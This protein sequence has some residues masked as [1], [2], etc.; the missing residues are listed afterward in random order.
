M[1]PR[2]DGTVRATDSPDRAKK[3]LHRFDHLEDFADPDILIRKA[4]QYF[5]LLHADGLRE[6]RDLLYFKFPGEVEAK[7]LG[8]SLTRSE[9][10]ELDTKIAKYPGH[11]VQ[12]LRLEFGVRRKGDF[13]SLQRYIKFH[14]L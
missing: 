1:E 11:Q 8:R 13:A 6:V 4:T 12:A 5:C 3:F 2:T 9:K 14:A 7:C 10:G